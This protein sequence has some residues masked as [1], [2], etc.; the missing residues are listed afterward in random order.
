[1]ESQLNVSGIYT[2]T[3]SIN[4]KMYIGYGKNVRKRLKWHSCLL[5]NNKHP[6]DRLQKSFNKYG[7]ENFKFELLVEC[8]EKFLASEEHYWA[9]VLNVHDRKYGFNL[10]PTHPD[11]VRL[12]SKETSEKISKSAKGRVFTQE[13]RDKISKAHLGKIISEKEKERLQ[14]F[15][16]N[17]IVSQETKDKLS[18]TITGRKYTDEQKENCSKARLKINETLIT[19]EVCGKELKPTNYWMHHGKFCGIK[20][21]MS[22]EQKKKLSLAKLGKEVN[23]GKVILQYDLDNNLIQEWSS[24]TKASKNTGVCKDSIQKQA[25]ANREGKK[26]MNGKVK[27]IWKYKN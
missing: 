15:N 8:E 13:H 19:C 6:N 14:S 17:R 26:Y 1:M 12:I 25:K 9:T 4:G 21:V 10:R 2:V 3:N 20:R 11:D 18:K 23:N 16:I 5:T 22:D 24:I 7:K 27:F